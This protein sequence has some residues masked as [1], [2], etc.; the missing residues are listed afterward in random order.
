MGAA[1]CALATTLVN[2]LIA[3]MAWLGVGRSADYRPYLVFERWSWPR[4]AD[5]RR[6]LGLG[7]PIGGTFLVDVTAF[8]F[9][10]LFVARLG[11]VTSAAHQ[12][13]ANVAAV[14]Y[15]LPLATGTAV[16]VLVAQAL[17]ARNFTLARS[18]GVTGLVLGFGIAAT[19]A[20]LLVLGA[21]R[22]AA[23]YSSDDRVRDLAASL[24]VLVSGYHLFDALQAVN[25]NTLRGYKRAVVPL[26]INATGMW[27]VGLAGG[28][29]VGLTDVAML[30]AIGVPTP[31]GVRGFWLAAIVGMAIATVGIIVYFL[32]VSAP[33]RARADAEIAST[34]TSNAG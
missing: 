32:I 1:G 7:L 17:G 27:V 24:L 11:A 4:W 23:F 13:A 5:Q 10:A 18:T 19:S 6:L 30:R 20:T 22:V 16:G 33:S 29:V 31:L 14:M 8:T 12:I 9:M 21:T 25:V 26:M 2:W 34:Q 28:V 3:A 15:M